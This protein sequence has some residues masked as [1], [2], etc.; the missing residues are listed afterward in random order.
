LDSEILES[1]DDLWLSLASSAVI[2]AACNFES[3][4]LCIK[5]DTC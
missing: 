1:C 2:A 5:S 4:V 3:P